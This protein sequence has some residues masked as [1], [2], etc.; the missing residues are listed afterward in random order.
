MK[1]IRTTC[2]IAVMGWIFAADAAYAWHAEGH[3]MAAAAAV[4]A[5]PDDVPGWFR[6]NAAAVG[7]Q[8]GEPDLFREKKAPELTVAEGPEHFI[9][10][11]LLGGRDLPGDRYKYLALCN[12]LKLNARYAGTLPYSVTEWEQKLM[13]A[14]AQHRRWPDDVHIRERCLVY[15]GILAHYS[16]DL[17]QPL[18]TTIHYDGRADANNKSPRSGIHEKVD[19][20]PTILV[21][22]DTL[23]A[24]PDAVKAIDKVFPAVVTEIRKC[25]A[26]VDKVYEMEADLPAVRADPAGVKDHVRAFTQ[27]RMEA[28]AAFTASLI[29]TAWRDSA[30]IEVP[31]WAVRARREPGTSGAATQPSK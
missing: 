9:D 22:P 25:N 15:A 4:R 18:H 17:C 1:R 24:T 13:I 27:E 21:N 19:G 6:E 3:D 16:S 31:E 30:N 5:L 26:M 8:S 7:R 23:R 11:E 2:L 14:F 12:E 10:L 28:S 20:L 29:L